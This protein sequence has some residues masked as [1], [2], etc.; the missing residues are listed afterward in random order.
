[1]DYRSIARDFGIIRTRG[2][3]IRT[4]EQEKEIVSLFKAIKDADEKNVADAI[5]TLL[6]PGELEE[7]IDP[8][9]VV[10]AQ[11]NSLLYLL[12]EGAQAKINVVANR[13]KQI[14]LE[15]LDE[16]TKDEIIE[17][18][19]KQ[20]DEINQH[21][22]AI[23]KSLTILALASWNEYYFYKIAMERSATVFKRNWQW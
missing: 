3:K 13:I 23:I 19:K 14:I 18:Y 20:L 9:K 16:K 8:S 6:I 1:M 22:L 17:R 12:A 2:L 15:K 11:G 4:P 10:D 5:A 21:Y 7:E